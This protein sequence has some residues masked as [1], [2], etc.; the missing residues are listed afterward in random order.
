MGRRHRVFRPTWRT[1]TPF[2]TTIVTRQLSFYARVLAICNRRMLLVAPVQGLLYAPK[3]V[4]TQFVTLSHRGSRHTPCHATDGTYPRNNCEQSAFL[5]AYTHIKNGVASMPLATRNA[6]L[7]V[8]CYIYAT[9]QAR[10]LSLTVR[11]DRRLS[12]R[13]TKAFRPSQIQVFHLA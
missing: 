4:S 2:T 1:I 12:S 6:I 5:G 13:T 11:G 9:Q 8:L 3:W 7:Y 10:C